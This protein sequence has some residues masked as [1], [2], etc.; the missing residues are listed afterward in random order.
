MLALW[1]YYRVPIFGAMG[2][3]TE[4]PVDQVKPAFK[5]IK[6]PSKKK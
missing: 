6:A 4:T 3:T 2:A 5:P 1:Y